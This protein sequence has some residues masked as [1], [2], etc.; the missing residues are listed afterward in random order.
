[1]PPGLLINAP[2]KIRKKFASL[3][4]ELQPKKYRLYYLRVNHLKAG[5][6]FDK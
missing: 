6:K 1:L 2:E 5:M 4:A 3:V